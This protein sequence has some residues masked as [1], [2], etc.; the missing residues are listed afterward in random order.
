M[1]TVQTCAK[2][3]LDERFPGISFSDEGVC[4]YC[5]SSTPVRHGEQDDLERAFRELL[6][7][8]GSISYDCLLCYSGGKDSTYALYLLRERYGLDV[9]TFTFD[10]GFLS[11]STRENIRRL[12]EALDVDNVTFAPSP[13]ILKTI[14]RAC[15]MPND[16][17]SKAALQRASSICNACINFVKFGALKVSLE[18][19][20]PMIGF[21]WDPGQ[22]VSEK[23]VIVK[24]P[25]AFLVASQESFVRKLVPVAGEG[26]RK[27]FA[28]REQIEQ[29]PSRIP[30][31]V[32]PLCFTRYDLDQMHETLRGLGWTKP[33]NTDAN[34]T[35]CLLNGLANYLH[36]KQYGYCPYSQDVSELVRKGL[37]DRDTG[38][39]RLRDGFDL[40]AVSEIAGTLGVTD[41]L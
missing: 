5:S 1:T 18:K 33:S 37:I 10:N 25:P 12:T 36:E 3:V 15:A 2:C 30:F 8:L 20:I 9:L 27:Y 19:G 7:S 40:D 22:L 13:A 38:L 28:S 24:L 21:G 29:D 4:S 26:V 35:N 16:L 14:F 6:D 34:S 41:L 11:A 32:N 31:Y 23:S 17:F 39:R